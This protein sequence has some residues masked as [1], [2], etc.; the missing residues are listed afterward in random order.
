MTVDVR[1]RSDDDIRTISPGEFF[2]NELPSILEKTG[3]LAARGAR[4]LGLGPITVRAGGSTFTLR[5][6]PA[7]IGVSA[8]EGTDSAVAVAMSGAAFS[9]WVQ[10]IRSMLALLVTK[11]ADVQSGDANAALGWDAV[12]R[13]MVDG[14]GVYE[15]GAVPLVRPDGS[16][17]DIGK[18][19]TP[20]AD[21]AEMG[22]FLEQTGFLVLRGWVDAG[23]VQTIGTDIDR[24]L[25]GAQ[26]DDPHRWWARLENGGQACVRLKHFC[27]ISAAGKMAAES[28][29]FRRICGLTGDAFAFPPSCIEALIKPAGVLAGPSEIRWHKDCWQGRH[30]FFCSGLT[31][32]I[33]LAPSSEQT[34]G[35]RIMAGSHR[36]NFP[37]VDRDIDAIDLP[38]RT[39][40]GEPG[41]LT[42]HLSCAMHETL[43]PRQGERRLM[44]AG[45]SL[46][47]RATGAGVDNRYSIKHSAWSDAVSSAWQVFA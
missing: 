6:G 35:F 24:G 47:D 37:A 41:D 3:P 29:T 33:L 15:P 28:D 45:F 22:W 7:T 18:S 40:Y 39:L 20:D 4:Y 16:P 1:L 10:E 30:P 5:P 46:V 19:F 21:D 13:A 23:T 25:A 11:D 2:A 26:R 36:A 17:L 14:R 31:I 27:E 34:G 38:T 32:G 9:D 43:P 44:Y 12:L 42:V 8:G